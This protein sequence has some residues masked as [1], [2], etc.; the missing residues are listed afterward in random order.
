MA[1][2]VAD[3]LMDV[4]DAVPVA[5]AGV[6]RIE[7]DAA[8]RAVLPH[9]RAAERLAVRLRIAHHPTRVA[10][11]ECPARSVANVERAWAIERAECPHGAVLPDKPLSELVELRPVCVDAAISDHVATIVDRRRIARRSAWQ[12]AEID[13]LAVA[14]EEGVRC[15]LARRGDADVGRHRLELGRP[16]DVAD[17][18]EDLVSLG[19]EM[20][21]GG[22]ADAR[23]G[24]GD[25]G[26][27][28]HGAET[29]RRRRRWAGRP[30]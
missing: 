22:A 23:V 18:A 19:G 10:Q 2:R 7:I 29:T 14:I 26:D 28:W 16:P 24:A 20:D 11:R 3:D 30:P 21:G 25:D 13:D 1:V 5:V 17:G 6:R 12:H 27:K 8:H 15:A 4:V 9:E